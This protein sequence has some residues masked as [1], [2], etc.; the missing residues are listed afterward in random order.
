MAAVKQLAPVRVPSKKSGLFPAVLGRQC[1]PVETMRD[2]HDAA[3]GIVVTL[4]NAALPPQ[5]DNVCF[6][7]VQLVPKSLLE[8]PQRYHDCASKPIHPA[9]PPRNSPGG[10]ARTRYQGSN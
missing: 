8:G 10:I 3:V 6:D 9:P 4:F 5:I 2:K 1:L 7:L